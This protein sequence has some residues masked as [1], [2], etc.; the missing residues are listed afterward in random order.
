MNWNYLNTILLS[1]ICFLTISIFLIDISVNISWSASITDWLSVIIY[2]CTLAAAIWA[3]LTARSALEENRRIANDNQR[4]VN[5]QTEPFVDVSLEIMPQSINWIR[6]KIQNLGLSSAFNIKFTAT[7]FTP[8]N[9]ISQLV[10]N[11]FFGINFMRQGLSYLSKGDS[12]HTGFINLLDSD[13]DRGFTVDDFLN[14]K[15]TITIEF[16]DVLGK[17]YSSK[18]IISINDIH[19]TYRIGKSF[20]EQAIEQVKAL[21]QKLTY[22][23]NEQANFNYEYEKIHRGWTESDLRR[24]LSLIENRRRQDQWL[25]RKSEENRYIKPEKRQSIN[26][27]RKKNK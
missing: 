18:F 8:D 14:T 13:E 20:E 26:Q 12:R 21:N 22:I 1:I 23:K 6:L 27:L 17:K 19:G 10:V 24:T 3:A 7:D 4:L 16:E 5:S 2:S 25:N 9:D 15:F 11:Q